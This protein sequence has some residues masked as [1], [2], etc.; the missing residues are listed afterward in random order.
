MS[1]QESPGSDGNPLLLEPKAELYAQK[2]NPLGEM[3]TLCEKKDYK[4]Q[5]QQR[6]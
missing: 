6:K 2:K 5:Q 1:N 4:K 3:E